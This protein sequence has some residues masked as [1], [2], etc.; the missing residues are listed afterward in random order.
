M[1]FTIP[2]APGSGIGMARV[3]SPVVMRWK[4]QLTHSKLHKNEAEFEV[5]IENQICWEQT[6]SK[7][8][9]APAGELGYSQE[10]WTGT[11]MRVQGLMWSLRFCSI[12]PRLLSRPGTDAV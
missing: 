6:G 3:S 7:E 4:V 10:G 1:V 9:C 2:S 5:W 8:S 12:R 11:T